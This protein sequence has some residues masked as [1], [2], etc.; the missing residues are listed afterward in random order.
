L[1]LFTR[2]PPTETFTLSLHDALP[3]SADEATTDSPATIRRCWPQ[4]WLVDMR[5]LWMDAR[6]QQVAQLDAMQELGTD[7]VG[8]R[9]D[10]FAAVAGRVDVHAERPV[11][12]RR[13]H[14]VGDGAGDA[15]RI[16]I[17][18][19]A[20]G[21]VLQRFLGKAMVGA[22]VVLGLPRPVGRLA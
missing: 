16:C 21:Q 9:G 8:D 6:G 15:G 18:R 20:G 7:T 1:S 12:E 22:V 19:L 11:A 10:H 3:I 4:E 5:C 17:R 14:H 2:T 13:I